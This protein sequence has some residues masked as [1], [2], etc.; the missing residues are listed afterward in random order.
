[1]VN[2]VLPLF[3]VARAAGVHPFGAGTCA[4]ALLSV[5][6]FGVLPRVVTAV[7]GTGTVGLTLALGLAVPA[8][9]GGAWLLRDR[10]ALDAF[11]RTRRSR[12]TA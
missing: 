8:F 6:C 10:L 4:A 12:R 1:V 11:T 5:G 3:Q 7:A 2:N 9:G